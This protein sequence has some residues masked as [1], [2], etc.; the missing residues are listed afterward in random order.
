M[1]KLLSFRCC[2]IPDNEG[3]IVVCLPAGKACCFGLTP[4]TVQNN[5]RVDLLHGSSS[6]NVDWPAVG[7]WRYCASEAFGSSP[8]SRFSATLYC[9]W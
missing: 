1:Y 7:S 6:R 5:H 4:I 8:Q 3:V 9:A 2:R